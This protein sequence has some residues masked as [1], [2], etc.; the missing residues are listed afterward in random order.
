MFGKIFFKKGSKIDLSIFLSS[1]VSMNANNEG[2]FDVSFGAAHELIGALALDSS[3]KLYSLHSHPVRSSIFSN[4]FVII[5]KL[6][7]R[8]H[9][10]SSLC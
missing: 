3:S 9:K 5:F 1:K 4:Q 7:L 2:G 8:F 10:L 6:M